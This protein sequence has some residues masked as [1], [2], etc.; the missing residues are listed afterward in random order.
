LET[1]GENRTDIRHKKCDSCG[2]PLQER[3]IFSFDEK[4]LCKKCYLGDNE[5][6]PL[7]DQVIECPHCNK[8]LNKFTVVCCYC[9]NPIREVGT[10]SAEVKGMGIRIIAFFIAFLIFVIAGVALAPIST[11]AGG[12][13][14]RAALLGISGP[15]LSLMGLFRLLF[16]M[17]FKKVPVLRSFPGMLIGGVLFAVGIF[18]LILLPFP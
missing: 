10:V 8:P 12:S 2:T 18:L 17:V 5:L 6:G 15:L 7:A 13:Q 1:A 16:G 11:S 9:K 3:E 4:S 14:S